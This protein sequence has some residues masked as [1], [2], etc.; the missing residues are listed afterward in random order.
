MSSKTSSNW[1]SSAAPQ[2][3]TRQVF[4]DPSGMRRRRIARATLAIGGLAV[5]TAL[6]VW[7]ALSAQSWGGAADRFAG[8]VVDEAAAA[9]DWR[10]QRVLPFE[11]DTALMTAWLDTLA[12]QHAHVA[13]V[14]PGNVALRSPA[15]LARAVNEGHAVIA[16]PFSGR[17]PQ[18]LDARQAELELAATQLA[19]AATLSRQALWATC[20]TE[21]GDVSADA[22]ELANRLASRGLR[23]L[24]IRLPEEDGDDPMLLFTPKQWRGGKAAVPALTPVAGALALQLAL[25]DS[26]AGLASALPASLAPAPSAQARLGWFVAGSLRVLDGAMAFALWF[27]L[28]LVGIYLL[29]MLWVCRA[30]LARAR[31]KSTSP[32]PAMDAPLPPISVIVPAYNEEA[33]IVATVRSLLRCSYPSPVQVVVVD[34]GSRDS[35]H[36]RVLQ[37]FGDHPQVQLLRKP[38]GG[39]CS[40]L[41]LGIAMAR[42]EIVVCIDADTQLDAQALRLLCRHFGD[43]RVGAVAGNPKVGNRRNLLTRIQGLEY[44]TLDSV[45]R[46]AM[47]SLNAITCITGA[48]GAY[49]KTLVEQVGGYTHDTLAEDT[50]LTLQILSSGALVI[51]EEDAVAWTEAPETLVGFMRQRMRWM[52]GTVQAAFK[53]RGA[54]F[55]ARQ[56]SFGMVAVPYLLLLQVGAG[57]LLLPMVDLVMLLGLSWLLT[58][59]W[60]G[61]LLPRTGDGLTLLELW[62]VAFYVFLALSMAASFAMAA[63]ALRLDHRERLR[64]LIWLV[65]MQ[66][67]FRV[68]LG[69][70]AYRCIVRAVGGRPLGWGSLV[71]TGHVEVAEHPALGIDAQSGE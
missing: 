65:P 9:Q 57:C 19:L 16:A 4:D 12:L 10:G 11:P 31:R 6:A 25:I 70:T 36:E 5:A 54:L 32:R 67:I 48:L 8:P 71:R 26:S 20:S 58:G 69:I 42:T 51:Y 30:M 61:W 56:G 64:D 35:T 15:L 62:E 66:W 45:E 33:V 63:V 53:H 29:R 18:T 44:V 41:N 2:P 59:G 1:R 50:D 46:Q 22:V 68:L 39:K 27:T 52:Y 40:A 13:F 7:L 17:A 38:N 55:S 43:P 60:V 28:G 21:P 23:C 24:S 49:R 34:D 37:A 3:V 47:E 14:V